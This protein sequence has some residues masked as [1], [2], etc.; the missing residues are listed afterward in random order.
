MDE[1]PKALEEII[2]NFSN[3]APVPDRK[4]F[5]QRSA[6]NSV[7]YTG[8]G[9]VVDLKAMKRL[10]DRLPEVI[11]RM[12]I[13]ED[14]ILSLE[15]VDGS[16]L[17]G[18][19]EIHPRYTLSG[20]IGGLIIS[21]EDITGRKQADEQLQ[22]LNEELQRKI[23]QRTCELMEIKAQYLHAEKLSTIGRLSASIAHEFN[24]PLQGIMTILKGLRLRAT[25][26]DEDREILDVAINESERMKNL[27]RS[28]QDFSRPSSGEKVLVDV[29][30]SID[31]L[32]L[33]FRSDF[34][35]KRIS[36]VLNYAEELPRVMAIPDQIK[37]ILLNLFH[38]A[39]DACWQSGGGLIEITTSHEEER[40]T[41]A[42]KDS[43]L[44]IKAEEIDH[45]F[46]PFYTTKSVVGKG[47]GLGLSVCQEIVRNHQGEIRVESRPGEG[48]TFAVLLPVFQK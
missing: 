32:L 27:I 24:N 11:V 40:I 20:N 8:W 30:A 3:N 28:L 45:I 31:S 18:H 7:P 13:H 47:I 9:H 33:L 37:Q 42:I 10:F 38:N 12:N 14:N 48:A 2:M 16:V 21:I 15:I 4:P 25:M 29:H 46:E 44:G 5:E 19:W 35:Q 39:M 1:N 23:E 6:F 34:K 43:G 41:I 36:T 26:E 22:K 17:W